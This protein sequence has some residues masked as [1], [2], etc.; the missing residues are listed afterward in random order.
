MQLYDLYVIYRGGQTIFHKRFGT[1]EID[2][3]L[4]TAFLTAI[5]NFGKEL[6][7]GDEHLRVIE[8]GFS[9]VLLA[10]GKDIC[11]ALVCGT[12]SPEEVVTLREILDGILGDIQNQYSAILPS[13]RGNMRQLAGISDIVEQDLKQIILASAPPALATL[14]QNPNRFYFT[15]DD[16]GIDLYN[17]LLRTSDGFRAFI[18]KLNVPIEL[19]DMVLNE[20]R[21]AKK[22]AP[23]LS[24]ELDLDINRLMALLRTLRLRGIALIWM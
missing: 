21:L 17:T 24:S 22:N 14:I 8:K 19:V 6:L 9:K 18:R 12:D 5:E 15:I 2:Q 11:C 23:Q 1:I 3:D 10:Y 4:I 13:W 20:I 16:R 7:A